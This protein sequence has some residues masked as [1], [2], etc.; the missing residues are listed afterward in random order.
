[1]KPTDTERPTWRQWTALL[2][3]GLPMFMMATDFTAIFLAVPPV[4]ADLE[5]TATQLLWIVHIGELVAA[6]TLITMGWLT[7]RIG[8]RRLLL[9]AV[10]LYGIGSAL[11]AFA[12]DSE[13]FLAARILIGTATA[14]ASPAAFAMLRWLFTNARHHS[15]GF[16][17]V[18]GAFPVGSALGPPLTGLLLDH[19]WWGSVFLIN[20]PVAAIAV[21]GGLWL[22]PDATERT[23]DRIDIISVVVSMAAV[24]LIVFGLQEIAD[25]GISVTYMLSITGGGVLG[26]W[27][28]RRQRRI[29]N[30][31]VDLSLFA[32]RVLRILM[33][34]FLLSPL[35][36]M[37][38]D[39]ILIQ[40]L[41]IVVGISTSRLGLVLAVPGAA[42][43]AATALTPAL[44]VRFTPATVMTVGTSTGILGLL[45]VLAAVIA[46]PATWLFAVGMT[47]AALGASPPM[48]LGAQLVITSVS[49][50]QT[51]PVSAL[52]DISASLGSVLGIMVLGS[53]STAVYRLN[54]SSAAPDGLSDAEA[55]AAADSPGAAAAIAAERGG[56]SGE[57]LLTSVHDA[58]TWAT[59]TVY[60]AAVLIGVLI[61]FIV[62]RGLRG[63]RLPSDHGTDGSEPDR[64]APPA[65]RAQAPTECLPEP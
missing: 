7:G 35:A 49:R 3:L 45:V 31:L 6:G 17:V 16:A 12:P 9:L 2:L 38:A 39:F 59:V 64:V 44:T 24:M 36:F 19:F 55:A 22:F 58:W 54:L 30:P 47:I 53:L 41:Q 13:S 27:F 15:V 42:S 4:A 28:I 32:S 63:V 60:A 61:V 51:G 56:G 26:W 25:R 50:V 23:A 21:L 1:M 34:F 37:A 52:Q 62:G 65:T 57:Q 14:A 46:H 29:S 5:P 10:T 18:M 33:I 43:I 8:P 20:V 40:H 11:A 48:V